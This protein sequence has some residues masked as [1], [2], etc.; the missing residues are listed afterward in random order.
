MLDNI[1]SLLNS[2]TVIS[3]EKSFNFK[4]WRHIC[5]E[6]NRWIWCNIIFWK[7]A[8]STIYIFVSYDTWFYIMMYITL[9]SL[10]R[11]L[12]KTMRVSSILQVQ[13]KCLNTTVA[14]GP[15]SRWKLKW[16][17]HEI[18]SRTPKRIVINPDNVGNF[19]G[20][21]FSDF[22][23]VTFLIN[24]IWNGIFLANHPDIVGSTESIPVIS[25]ILVCQED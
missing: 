9:K 15:L 5:V 14:P 2:W 24:G 11:L 23:F 6:K 1:V 8:I 16:R 19:M 17:H 22:R 21:G 7:T 18:G 3:T 12:K 25:E 10:P 4:N 13:F 20:H